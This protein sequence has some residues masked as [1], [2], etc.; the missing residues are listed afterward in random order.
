MTAIPDPFD[1]GPVDVPV[2]GNL[3]YGTVDE[4]DVQDSVWMDDAAVLEGPRRSP[5]DYGQTG[6]HEHGP[7]SGHYGQEHEPHLGTAIAMGFV[8]LV[9]QDGCD[10]A[11]GQEDERDDEEDGSCGHD[12][13]SDAMMRC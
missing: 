11:C 3:C 8:V 5:Q 12:G 1:D 10:T 13:P 2:E 4:P 9:P 7:Y 6:Q